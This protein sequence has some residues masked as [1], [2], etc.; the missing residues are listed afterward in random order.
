MLKVLS[1]LTAEAQTAAAGISDWQF[2][3]LLAI[4]IANSLVICVLM[5]M[6]RKHRNT[7]HVGE[8]QTVVQNTVAPMTAAVS[9]ASANTETVSIAPTVA[10]DDD[11]D[12]ENDDGENAV[13]L[14][15]LSGAPKP[16]IDEAYAKL[17]EEQK[18]YFDGLKDYALNKP[19]ARI[20]TGKFNIQVGAGN[21][22]YVRLGVKNGVTIAYFK[23]ADEQF[24]KLR[25]SVSSDGVEFKVKET[26]M[27]IRDD[28][29][30]LAARDMI[31]LRVEQ[32]IAD[33]QLKKDERNA[34]RKQRRH[35][36][37]QARENA[38]LN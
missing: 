36:A 8:P 33:E 31:D 26:Q 29:A 14:K 35:N 11:E 15:V 16:D 10:I 27:P 19:N 37:K 2:G 6:Q 23:L 17:G 5:L 24:R 28:T 32:V 30:Y 34:A 12:D 7:S 20:K 25:R 21:N 38:T 9:A 18:R 22:Y 1:C 4:G 3:V 13:A